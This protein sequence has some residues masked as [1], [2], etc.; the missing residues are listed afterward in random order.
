MK[1]INFICFIF[2]GITLIVAGCGPKLPPGMPKLNPCKITVTM[3]DKPLDKAR[4]ILY[5]DSETGGAWGYSGYTDSSGS[6]NMMTDGKYKGIP[7][8]K[9]S[10]CI[11]RIDVEKRE[12]KGYFEMK[13]LPPPKSTVVV[14]L[15]FN[16]PDET[17]FHLEVTDGKRATLDCAVTESKDPNLPKNYGM[18]KPK[19][20]K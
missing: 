18:P 17:P 16:D 12:Y 20:K 3:N 4:I 14:D 2:V 11:S 10:V 1:P 19:K 5:A 15:K 7:A 13:K 6:V 9:Y 8:G